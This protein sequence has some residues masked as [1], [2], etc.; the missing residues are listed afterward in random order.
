MKV[1]RV[2]GGERERLICVGMIVDQVVLAKLAA[3]WNGDLFLSPWANRIGSW[4]VEYFESYGKPPGKAI[5]SIYEAWASDNSD[6]DSAK[7]VGRFLQTLSGEYQRLKKELVPQYVLDTAG[8][9]FNRVKLI[10][11]RDA[12]T[13]FLEMNQTEKAEKLVNDYHRVEVGGGSWI[14]PLTD[15][16]ALESAF[17][18]KQ[19]PLIVYPEALGNFFGEA[20]E[21]DAFVG[22]Q[23]PEKT[24]KSWMLQDMAW[25][26]MQQ[27]R[28]VAYFE[29]GDMSQNQIMR[30]LMVRAAK[31]PWKAE[32]IKYP[33]FLQTKPEEPFGFP[34]FEEKEF[35]SVLSLATA[36]AALAKIVAKDPK[37]KGLFRM[38]CHPNSTISIL[39]VRAIL[40]GWVREG[41]IPDVVLIDYADIL[42][43]V[44]GFKDS[45]DSINAT[46]KHCRGLSQSLHCLVVTAT[47]ADAGASD[48]ETQSRS[49]FSEDKRKYS[50]VTGMV[51]INQTTIEKE[52][53]LMRLNWLVLREGEYVATKCCHTVGCLAISNPFVKS[54][55]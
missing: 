2:D 51:A 53:Q 16:S 26:A 17:V 6:D 47:Q 24:G 14:D 46:W 12:M 4:C 33:T 32:T 42:A 1:E 43:P 25:R 3:G 21:R 52:R 27:G 15:E 31:R 9:H 11:T 50:H 37:R 40:Q 55:W 30:R 8:K 22:I 18:S 41:W 36:K 29:V 13:G 38:S 35:K 5:Q 49:N 45:R 19:E 34:D 54:S 20:L 23:A 44:A 28:K 39:G 10:R 7:I 48:V